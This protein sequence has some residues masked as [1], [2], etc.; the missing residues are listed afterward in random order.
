MRPLGGTSVPTHPAPLLPV[1]TLF[2]GPGWVQRPPRALPVARAFPYWRRPR[3]VM[4]LQGGQ[5]VVVVVDL[6]LLTPC[7]P[8]LVSPHHCPPPPF[9]LTMGGGVVA[10]TGAL[11]FFQ[12]KPLSACIPPGGFFAGREGPCQGHGGYPPRGAREGAVITHSQHTSPHLT[13]THPLLF[14]TPGR[15]SC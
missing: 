4:C 10:C 6:P 13:P 8:V 7:P 14:F 2:P 1:A 12:T 11:D 5:V 3:G 9:S 15:C